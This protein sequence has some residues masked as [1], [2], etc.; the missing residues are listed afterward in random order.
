MDFLEGGYVE[1]QTYKTLPVTFTSHDNESL[2]G[3]Q[4]CGRAR[5]VIETV[6]AKHDSSEMQWHFEED[7]LKEE[8]D[9]GTFK[10]AQVLL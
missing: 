1:G 3:L 4:Q 5:I 7:R 6:H 8:T 9:I 2:M 10:L